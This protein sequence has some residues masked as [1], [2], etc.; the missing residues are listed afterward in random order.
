MDP[1]EA[2]PLLAPFIGQIVVIDLRSTYVCLGTLAGVDRDF[3]EVLDADL[4][5]FR[6]S[7]ATREVYVY[8]SARVGVRRNRARV[9]V[10]RDEVIAVTLFA[11]VSET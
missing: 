4:H 10:R 7:S 6:D 11:D 3:L 1:H 5:D 2:S 9:I 8:N